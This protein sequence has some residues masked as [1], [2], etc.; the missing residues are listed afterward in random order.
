[1][2]DKLFEIQTDK[3]V[4]GSRL[5]YN[6]TSLTSWV[7][8]LSSLENGQ[9]MFYCCYNLT[10]L[11]ADSS[12]SPVNLSSLTDAFCMFE[13]CKK[14]SAFTSDSSG[15]PVNLSSLENGCRM[16]Y[17]CSALTSFTS[18]LSS[19]TDGWGM[20][21]GCLLDTASVKNIAETIKTCVIDSPFIDI[22][23][24]NSSPT[25]E[26]HT[27]FTQIHNKGW[28]VYVNGSS[29]AYVPATASLDETGETQ[30]APIPFWAK[31][32]PAAEETAK[33][34][35]SDGNFFNILG[36]QFIYVDDPE[37]YGMFTC[38]EDAA[39]NMRLTIYVKPVTESETET[40]TIN[41][42]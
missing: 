7:G 20:F 41:Q 16:F 15:S 27:Y 30:T 10:A 25:E 6:N 26:E 28:K 14:L 23:I 3:I 19:L 42:N 13:S 21:Q 38:E 12:G 31:P 32:V 11:D 29:D 17:G 9:K 2:A 18:D 36:G 1:M 33:Y 22:G 24:G 5:M 4:N 40:E 35:D 34:I 37:T 39:A 8:D